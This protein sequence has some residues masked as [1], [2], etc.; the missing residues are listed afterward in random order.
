VVALA[1]LS[2]CFMQE[3]SG[4]FLSATPKKEA[5]IVL[6]ETQEAGLHRGEAAL[7]AAQ[8]LS[9]RAQELLTEASKAGAS[10]AVKAYAMSA[11]KEFYEADAAAKDFSKEEVEHKKAATAV[12]SKGR[13]GV[14]KEEEES[15]EVKE[16]LKKL[17]VKV[18]S[19][20]AKYPLGGEKAGAMADTKKVGA[21]DV[22]K[23]NLV[24]SLKAGLHRGE[25]ALKAVQK[26][27]VKAEKLLTKASKDEASR[28]AQLAA[29]QAPKALQKKEREIDSENDEED[30]EEDEHGDKQEN[31]E[32]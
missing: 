4:E 3:V 21:P 14:Y 10:E 11:A 2:A 7:K 6:K 31:D 5:K 9:T 29:V 15:E 16:A 17:Q 26:V 25:A 19:N 22:A 20:S 24:A 13:G 1:I 32:D 30:E 12:K 27:G 8:K 18:K 23:N 28:V